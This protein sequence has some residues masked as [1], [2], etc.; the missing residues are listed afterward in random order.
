MVSEGEVPLPVAS[1][2]GGKSAFELTA[3]WALWGKRAA[4][5]RYHVLGCSDGIL[6]AP[7]FAEIVNRYASGTPDSL[8][9]YTVGWVPKTDKDPG[10]VT[11][12]I[13]E[14]APYGSERPGGRSRFDRLGRE[15]IFARL[16]CVR[17]ADLA[18]HGVSYTQLLEA[19]RPLEL[20]P[21]AMTS[22]MRIRIAGRRPPLPASPPGEL[23]EAVAILLLTKA[24]VCVLAPDELPVTDR[25]AFI[26]SVMALLPYGLRATLSASTWASSTAQDLKLRL[27]FASVQ[28]DGD[29]TRHVR[30]DEPDPAGPADLGSEAIRQYVDWLGRTGPRAPS[31]LAEQAE[32]YRF[33][34]EDIRRMVAALPRDATLANAFDDLAASLDD[35]DPRVAQA[36]ANRLGRYLDGPVDSAERDRFRRQIAARGLLKGHQDLAGNAQASVYREL[37]KLAFET[38]LSYA[39]YC[40]IDDAAGGPPRGSL[41][42]VML[43]L[44]FATVLPWL[45]TV[46]AEGE[47]T[48]KEL[49]KDLAK[50][51]AS[52]ATPLDELRRDVEDLRPAHRAIAYDFAVRYLRVRAEDPAAELKQRGYLADTLEAAFPHDL[53]AQQTRL[54][55]TLRRVY[56]TPLHR[57][58][59]RELF[60]DQQVRPTKALEAALVGFA[61]SASTGSF[62]AQQAGY[63][64]SRY[65]DDA[66][67]DDDADEP[68][69]GRRTGIWQLLLRPRNQRDGDDAGTGLNR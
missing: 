52:A 48:D 38:P 10:F 22:P 62:A 67:E 60:A 18:E 3:E 42:S 15:I 43:E 26:D 46:K 69:P 11:I 7:D 19:V 14:H 45:L 31:L 55:A 64:R 33:T 32:P 27:F 20:P 56:G 66:D 63:A 37:L 59:I 68:R 2:A 40:Q 47:F 5:A 23:A 12:A 50:Q 4:D 17:H 1:K 8:P 21:P 53:A 65:T 49:V 29:R 57:S 35:G 25:L 16:F 39:S 9:Q 44:K 13:H 58:Q 51:G 34:D 61:S 24:P 30:W 54:T 36:E 28:R 6:Q 41:R